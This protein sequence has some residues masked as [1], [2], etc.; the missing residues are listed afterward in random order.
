VPAPSSACIT[1]PEVVGGDLH[2]VAL[3]DVF[4]TRSQA[5]R[6]APPIEAVLEAAF[7]PCGPQRDD[8]SFGDRAA[9]GPNCRTP[10]PVST[11]CSPI[12]EGMPPTRQ[13]VSQHPHLALPA[14]L[15]P[16]RNGCSTPRRCSNPSELRRHD[17]VNGL[18]SRLYP[19]GKPD[20]HG[21]AQT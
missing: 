19:A 16:H 4:A 20:A 5:R 13:L 12:V 10:A 15:S 17:F 1:K 7:N 14:A 2:Q 18:L 11:A 9:I 3:L 21:A 8:F 6:M